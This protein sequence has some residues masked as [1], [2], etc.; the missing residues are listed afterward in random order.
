MK[1][2]DNRLCVCVCARTHARTYALN[3]LTERKK[4]S[5]PLLILLFKKQRKFR[6]LTI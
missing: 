1:E 5:G 6:S 4:R 2:G 3:I